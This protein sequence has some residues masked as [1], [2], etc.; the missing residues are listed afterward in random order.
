MPASSLGSAATAC[1]V[2]SAGR[3]PSVRVTVRIA[4]TASRSVAVATSSRP[5]S[6]QRRELWPDTRIVEA[7]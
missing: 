3:M 4:A 7:R 2:S 5:A 6:A 1:E